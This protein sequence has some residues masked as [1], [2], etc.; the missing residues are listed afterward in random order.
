MKNILLLYTIYKNHN[1]H[2][3]INNKNKMID[4][5]LMIIYIYK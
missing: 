3:Y 1:K 5:V 4:Y 2:N